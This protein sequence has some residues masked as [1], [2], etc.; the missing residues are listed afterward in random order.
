MKSGRHAKILEIIAEYP[1]ET[2]DE[3]ISRLKDAGYKATQATISR[4]IK[5]LRLVKTLGSDG[6]YRYTSD[7]SRSAD[8]RSNFEQLFSGSV[9]S[10]DAA[11]NIVVIKTLSGMAN[12]V[13]AAMD[14]TENSAIVGTIAGDDTI[15]VAC[16]SDEDAGELTETLKQY[17]VKS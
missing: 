1:V 17:N 7:I 6:K 10:I 16:R 5:D 12:A 8:L 11:K 15:F 4:D 9:I 14:S 3:I 13:C 2:Q